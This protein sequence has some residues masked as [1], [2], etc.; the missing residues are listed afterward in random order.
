[1]KKYDV[2]IVN[3]NGEKIL[4]SCLESVYKSSVNPE[5][6]IIYDNNSADQ[7]VG[8]ISNN[9]PKI[10]LIRG[11]KNIGFGKGNNEAMKFA[12]SDYI[13]FMNNDLVLDKHCAENLIAFLNDKKIAIV[14]PLIYKG[15]KK[16]ENQQIYA[17]GAVLERSGF[18]YALYDTDGDRKNLNCFSGAC[19]MARSDVIK[20]F[21]FEKRFFLYYEEPELVCR[22]LKKSMKIGR[23]L[24]AKC[25]HLENYSSPKKNAAG[26]VFRQF[27]SI[28][29]KWYMIGKHWPILAIPATLLINYF[30]LLLVSGYM[31]RFGKI[32]QMSLL[33]LAPYN[34]YCGIIN[35]SN[36]II[37]KNWYKKLDPIAYKK[38]FKLGRMVF[39]KKK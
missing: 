7:S 24:D 25:Y 32:R 2:V 3:F 13:L 20:K 31:L 33:Y 8:L 34:F 11:K 35:R 30:H 15:W 22:M 4:K 39:S 27:Y 19:F 10:K 36:K 21:K 29:N 16:T 38:Y 14:N 26:V 28:Q 1:M 23:C 17:S 9:Y 37:D 6:V 12:K 18:N 5:K